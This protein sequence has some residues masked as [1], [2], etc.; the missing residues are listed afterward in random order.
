MRELPQRRG[1]R[2]MTWWFFA[3]LFL[4]ATSV[5]TACP[6]CLGAFRSS[7]AQQ[8]VDLPNAVL[9]QPS[10]DGGYQVVA[11]IK[12]EGPAGGIIPPEEV[13]LDFV[14][15][16]SATLLIVRDEAWSMWV[17][18]GA[19]GIE[20][21]SWLR[22]IAAGKRPVDMNTDEW[23]AQLALTLPYL[24]HREPLVAEIAYGELAA[25]PYA[26][27]LA[28][29][30]RLD[31]PAIRRW[32]ADPQLT[33]RQPLYLLLLGIA[34]DA[35]DA[36]A[37]ELRLEAL[38]MARDATNLASMIAADLQLRGPSHMAWV[39]AKYMGDRL[40]STRELEAALL[41]LSV[42]GNANG[43]IPRERVI[44]SYGLF[45]Q[46]HRELAGFVAEDL[47]AWQYWGAVPSYLA[48]IKSNIRQ[49]FKSRVAISAYL[50]QSPVGSLIDS[51][52]SVIDAPDQPTSPVR[53]TISG[54]P[55]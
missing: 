43:A 1:K 48:L 5:A 31:A 51:G 42:L 8:L 53:P 41:A 18:L 25:A 27:L 47:A 46:E 24:E 26:A 19:V 45:I 14:V 49:D 38:W 21:A 32:V 40:R 50:H 30:P 35:S 33:A 37:L 7:V 34:G 22:Q 44:R 54:V 20:H 9:A 15:D 55:Q 2:A 11:V 13:E 52:I 23:Q 6:L 12:G 10:A 17:G 36:A 29:K 3:A 28:A 4:C 39:D 16:S